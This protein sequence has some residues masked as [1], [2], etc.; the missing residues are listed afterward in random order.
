MEFQDYINNLANPKGVLN[1]SMKS[2]KEIIKNQTEI[3]N[4]KKR[5]NFILRQEF[6]NLT[7]ECSIKN[8]IIFNF[9]L[10]I[11]FLIFAIP[12]ILSS[13]TT[14][15]AEIRYDDWYIYKK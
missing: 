4:A 1:K 12:I 7:P 9:V 11:M 15:R 6:K 10:M 14:L 8:S 3:I 2:E 5:G 13:S